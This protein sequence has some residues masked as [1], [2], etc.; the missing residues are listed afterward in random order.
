MDFPINLTIFKLQRCQGRK[1]SRT[2]TR[3]IA[4][5]FVKGLK[6]SYHHFA[7]KPKFPINHGPSSRTY[8][9]SLSS[10]KY[11]TKKP[12][13]RMEKLTSPC[14]SHLSVSHSFIGDRP[15]H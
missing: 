4:I 13:G 6:P 5:F 9:K 12:F 15:D 14:K 11:T 8:D 3:I 10:S 2:H 7:N 1:K